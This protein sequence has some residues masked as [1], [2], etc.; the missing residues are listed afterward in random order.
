MWRKALFKQS[1][2]IYIVTLKYIQNLLLCLQARFVNKLSSV[3]FDMVLLYSVTKVPVGS[4][5]NIKLVEVIGTIN[6]YKNQLLL[7]CTTQGYT[8]A[9]AL[10]RVAV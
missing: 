7:Y 8:S 9:L 2:I 4:K 10:N 6:L 3:E 1:K 5:C